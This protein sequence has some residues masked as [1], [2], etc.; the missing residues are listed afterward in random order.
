MRLKGLYVLLRMLGS[1]RDV[2]ESQTLEQR[3]DAA[4]GQHDAEPP[5][6]ARREIL[7]APPDHAVLREIGAGPNPGRHFR[8]LLS[9]ELRDAARRLAIRQS[10]EPFGI[11]AVNPVAQRLTVHATSPSRLYPR[12]FLQDQRQCQ[13]PPGRFD[14]PSPL[15]ATT[16]IIRT[17]IQA[18]DRNTLSH[19]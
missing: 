8:L 6:D 17:Q 2:P 11:V 4:L 12:P 7:A 3:A 5:L 13:H 15:C 10:P 16:Q 18:R 19:R 1:D 14:A 9:R